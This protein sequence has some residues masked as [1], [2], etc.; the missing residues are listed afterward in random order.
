MITLTPIGHIE[1]EYFSDTDRVLVKMMESR[2]IIDPELVEGLKGLEKQT[3]VTVVFFFNQSEGYELM[4][5]PRHQGSREKRGVFA[6]RSPNRPNPI[7]VTPVE[8]LGIEGNVVRVRGLDAYNGT[9]V[10]DLKPVWKRE[11]HYTAS[12]DED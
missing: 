7:G 2:I 1:N 3:E 8:L 10:L 5:A 6:L 11:R 12:K 9:P 4:Q